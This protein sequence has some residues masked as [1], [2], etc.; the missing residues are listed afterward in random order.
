MPGTRNSPISLLFVGRGFKAA[1]A[2]GTG[3]DGPAP[4]E[5]CGGKASDWPAG[6]CRNRTED[7]LPLEK[8][9][10]VQV[11]LIPEFSDAPQRCDAVTL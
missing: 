6:Q 4:A 11:G 10:I 9:A 2:D 8:V 7:H 1:F 3:A 5:G